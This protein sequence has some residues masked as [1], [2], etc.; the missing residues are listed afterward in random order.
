M[1]FYLFRCAMCKLGHEAAIQMRLSLLQSTINTN[2]NNNNDDEV[3]D[4][5]YKPNKKLK[6]NNNEYEL[7]DLW[8]SKHP[9]V[10]GSR[11]AYVHF[12]CAYFS[13]RVW[14][15]YGE[16]HPWRNV[17]R[18]VIRACSLTCRTCN[19]RGATVGCKTKR[20]N[21]VYHIT[22]AIQIGI[23]T[24]EN[25]QKNTGFYCP[26]HLYEYQQSYKRLN[27][28]SLLDIARGR[29]R[30]PMLIC[31]KDG[32]CMLMIYVYIHMYAHTCICV[33]VCLYVSILRYT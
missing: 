12:H 5:E 23:I 29:E 25:S 26:E 11:K 16:A 27:D 19:M 21:V 22:C 31:P 2:N 10:W 7:D 33:F 1:L 14:Y 28:A 8:V 17:K 15:E 20:C 6:S 4:Y 30:Y 32:T 9:L 13:P 18:E 24:K 3:D